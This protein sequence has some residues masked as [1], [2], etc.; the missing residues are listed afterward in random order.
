MYHLFFFQVFLLVLCSMAYNYTETLWSTLLTFT[1]YLLKML[2]TNCGGLNKNA[3]HRL[4][5][6]N[7][8]FPVRRLF[9]KNY[10]VWRSWRKYVTGSFEASKVHAMLSLLFLPPDCRS[11]CELSVIAP[12]LSLSA[13]CYA[14]HHEDHGLTPETGRKSSVKYVFK[15]S[16]ISCLVLGVSS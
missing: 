10:E 12:N 8:Q 6:L 1:L 3:P 16:F 5:Y 7:V 15:F 2:D 11:G 9:R 14:S 4:I 13:C